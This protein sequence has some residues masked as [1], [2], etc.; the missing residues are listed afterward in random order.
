MSECEW[1]FPEPRRRRRSRQPE[2]IEGYAVRGG[3]RPPP[4]GWTSPAAK[5]VG[6][7]SISFV[8]WTAKIGL[9]ATLGL[10]IALGIWFLELLA[11]R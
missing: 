3:R 10:V 2:L 1:D 8:V 4:A 11:T 6:N 7:S 5:E 9:A